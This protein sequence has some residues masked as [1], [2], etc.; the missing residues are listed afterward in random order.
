M[1]HTPRQLLY[2][3]S[4]AGKR[5]APAGKLAPLSCT[6]RIA[7][8]G[9]SQAKTGGERRVCKLFAHSEAPHGCVRQ[10]CKAQWNR[11]TGL[12]RNMAANAGFAKNTGSERRVC[13]A[14]PAQTFANPSLPAIEGLFS[15]PQRKTLG[16]AVRNLHRNAK[17]GRGAVHS[18]TPSRLIASRRQGTNPAAGKG[19]N[20]PFGYFSSASLMAEICIGFRM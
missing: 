5:K 18:A 14:Q 16:L 3:S 12:Q 13:N 2:E 6:R 19:R 4:T 20:P 15:A 10:V 11:T 1:E 9:W 7:R 8:G 17:A